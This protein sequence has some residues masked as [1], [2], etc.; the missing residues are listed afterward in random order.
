MRLGK[1]KQDI[2]FLVFLLFSASLGGQAGLNYRY[3]F[4]GDP[5]KSEIIPGNQSLTINYSISELNFQS[6]CNDNG[7]FY[8]VA[9]PGHVSS[10]SPGKPELP[11]LSRLITVPEGFEY[12]VR[13]S[14]I[15]SS[16]INPSRKNIKGI[17][18]PAQAGETKNP[19]QN[20]NEFLI[21]KKAYSYPGVLPSDTVKIERLGIVRNKRLANLMISPVHYN[22]R[23][24]VL[25]V[26]TSMKI[27]ITYTSQ[28]SMSEKSLTT[29]SPLIIKSLDKSQLIII[30][31]MLFLVIP[32]D[33]SRWLL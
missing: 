17:L 12:E 14:E 22:P 4:D 6:V 32:Q 15:R 24:N 10:T 19:V 8:R 33:L 3:Q 27:E 16:R 9:I 25:E 31:E 29:E 28:G 13:I 23:S 26:I 1:D 11:V 18:Y 5:G 30:R 2:L 21:D 20:R 7:T